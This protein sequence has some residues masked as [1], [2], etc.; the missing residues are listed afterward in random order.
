MKKHIIIIATILSL[1][2][3]KE[4]ISYQE[5]IKNYNNLIF[6]A[7]N[8]FKNSRFQNAVNVS[9]E[10]IKITDTLSTALMLR[11]NSYL[12]LNKHKNA[13]EDFD[14]VIELEGD[15][16]KAYFGR[17]IANQGLNEMSDFKDDIDKYLENYSRDVVARNV[18][19]DYNLKEANFNQAIEDYTVCIKKFPKKSEYY[20]KRA[21]TYALNADL[22][23]SVNDY[24]KYSKLDSKT[25]K[26]N[27]TYQKAKIY[28][29]IKNYKKALDN[30]S[31]L[32]NKIKNPEI[33]TF[34]GDCNLNLKEYNK[35]IR[36][37]TK[38]L[39]Q[40]PNNISIIE[41]RAETYLIV[42]NLANANNDYR[43]IAILRNEEA[44][45]F[46]KYSW[47]V[48]FGFLYFFAGNLFTRKKEKRY[49]N[50]KL[51]HAYQSLFFGGFFGGQYLF[52]GRNFMYIIYSVA[53]FIFMIINSFAFR[54]HYN[55][56]DLWLITIL[57]NNLGLKVFYF[58]C[59]L[60]IIDFFALPFVVFNK[61][62]KFLTLVNSKNVKQRSY[63]I[64]NVQDELTRNT[65]IVKEL[66]S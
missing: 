62:E 5:Q 24:E 58:I 46:S 51:S 61:N 53:V 10:A 28:F 47:L 18:R 31:S 19:G 35:A 22:N 20:F 9:S 42:K 4:K 29:E 7:S 54:F 49:R 21:N 12:K 50:R 1:T 60:I 66:V 26:S 64:E 30:F 13:Y 59:S 37:Y 3:C 44:G 57:E 15:K 33:L 2:G 48:L 6:Q 16:S 56:F 52:T 23:L 27:V 32:E 41:K 55:N 65:N 11:G 45:F 40:N 36:Y 39:L 34:I 8:E 43:K 17:A 14:E 63:S 38:Y 25:N